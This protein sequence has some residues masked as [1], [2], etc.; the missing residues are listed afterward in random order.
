MNTPAADKT[1]YIML[2]IDQIKLAFPKKELTATINRSNIS[3]AQ[4]RENNSVKYLKTSSGDYPVIS[5]TP[6]LGAKPLREGEYAYLAC[7]GKAEQERLAIACQD[8]LTLEL[9][10]TELTAVPEVMQ[11][12]A[13]PILSLLRDGEEV[14]LISNLDTIVYY[15]EQCSEA[16]RNVWNS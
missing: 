13:T 12:S 9:D 7:L 11:T 15:L 1:S 2:E 8:Y 3:A 14:V 6:Q 16:Y 5:F 4:L 10:A